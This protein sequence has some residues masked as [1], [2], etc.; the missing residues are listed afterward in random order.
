MLN[1]SIKISYIL[2]MFMILFRYFHLVSGLIDLQR[3][4]LCGESMCYPGRKVGITGWKLSLPRSYLHYWQY[5]RGIK[6]KNKLSMTDRN[7][8]GTGLSVEVHCVPCQCGEGEGKSCIRLYHVNIHY[9]KTKPNENKS[10]NQ[11]NQTNTNTPKSISRK[12]IRYI[13][14]GFEQ[15]S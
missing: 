14:C 12:L 15:M 11:P 9:L 8:T 6:M 2:S 1:H 7:C 4:V 5:R 3:C 10:N 13:G